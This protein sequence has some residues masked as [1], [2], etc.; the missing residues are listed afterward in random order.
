MAPRSAELN[1]KVYHASW[2]SKTLHLPSH[3]TVSGRSWNPAL[4][5]LGFQTDVTSTPKRTVKMKANRKMHIFIY[6]MQYREQAPTNAPC[7]FRIT[8]KAYQHG[9]EPRQRQRST[10]KTHRVAPRNSIGPGGR[11]YFRLP[12]SIPRT[13]ARTWDGGG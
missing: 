4:W 10:T 9:Q 11:T 2:I 7:R 13:N 8:N 6:S 3:S 1:V 12:E 5:A